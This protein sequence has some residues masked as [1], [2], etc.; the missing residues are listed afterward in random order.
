MYITKVKPA[1]MNMSLN[2]HLFTSPYLL[3][4]FPHLLSTNLHPL[5]TSLPQHPFPLFPLTFPHLPQHLHLHLL[6]KSHL[7][8][9]LKLERLNPLS[10]IGKSDSTPSVKQ[11]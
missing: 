5:S 10:S 2:P 9:L 1:L 7:H 11:S 3:P 4:L 6:S 8:L